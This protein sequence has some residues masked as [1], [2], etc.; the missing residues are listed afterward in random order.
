MVQWVR[1]RVP[2]ARVLSSILG[3]GTRS[4]MPYLKILNATKNAW[5]SQINKNI[6]KI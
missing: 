6:L 1:L 4:H 3:Q 2:K 5:N